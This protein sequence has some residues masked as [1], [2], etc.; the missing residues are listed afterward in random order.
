MSKIINTR[1]KHK[2]ATET[3][4]NNTSFVPLLGEIII[5][6]TDNNYSYQ[7]LKI[8]DGQTHVTELPFLITMPVR[9]IDYWTEDDISEIKSYVD[10]AI[11]TG[12]W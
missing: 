10:T 6:D 9:G 12:E 5:Y 3:A 1:I 2:H 7:R 11:L 8:G 4:W